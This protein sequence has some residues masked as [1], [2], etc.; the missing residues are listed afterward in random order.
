LDRAPVRTF[1]GAS[2]FAT[3]KQSSGSSPVSSS[4]PYVCLDVPLRAVDR[5]K[6]Y[7][8]VSVRPTGR[9]RRGSLETLANLLFEG[10]QPCFVESRGCIFLEFMA[11]SLKR[12]RRE[13]LGRQDEARAGSC[14]GGLFATALEVQ[15]SRSHDDRAQ[16]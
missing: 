2:N 7:A 15:L 8:A 16:A 11:E 13:V 5:A 12:L 10:S 1:R 6:N 9:V 3:A 14:M 4:E